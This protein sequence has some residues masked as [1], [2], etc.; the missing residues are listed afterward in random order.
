MSKAEDSKNS[1][2][3]TSSLKMFNQDDDIDDDSDDGL[4]DNR[5]VKDNDE[6]IL[7]KKEHSSIMADTLEVHKMVSKV[8]LRLLSV[9]SNIADLFLTASTTF[10]CDCSF[11]HHCPSSMVTI[12]PGP[13]P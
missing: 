9:S 2:S 1:I 5:D 6:E 3:D 13:W 4:P 12:L 8:R 7:S 11:N 10:L